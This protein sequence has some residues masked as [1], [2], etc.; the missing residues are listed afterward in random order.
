MPMIPA[1]PKE[2]GQ[3]ASPRS[4]WRQGGPAE[5]ELKLNTTTSKYESSAFKI[6]VPANASLTTAS[7]D[8]TG[9]YVLGQQTYA[10][11]DYNDDTAGHKAYKGIVAD[12]TRNTRVWSMAQNPV[13]SSELAPLTARD[14]DYLEQAGDFQGFNDGYELFRFNVPV[15]TSKKITLDWEGHGEWFGSSKEF[16]I[17]IWNNLTGI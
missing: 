11:C 10:A 8:I 2:N 3:P 12:F 13:S 15:G 7:C 1:A 4:E 5:I 6:P 17:Y 9:K 14:D 16:T